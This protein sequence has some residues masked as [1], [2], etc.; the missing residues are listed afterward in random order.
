MKHQIYP[1]RVAQS[2]ERRY[3]VEVQ[4]LARGPAH[5]RTGEHG[6]IVREAD[7]ARVECC[8]PERGEQKAVVDVKALLGVT[9]GRGTMCQPAV[10]RDLTI[11]G[12][13]PP[14]MTY[15]TM[16]AGAAASLGRSIHESDSIRSGPE[17]DLEREALV[18]RFDQFER[19]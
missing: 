2:G 19:I 3:F 16:S 18:A 10:A 7:E 9:V 14:F 1:V 6:A 8:V 15:F 12:F 13:R 4:R 5:L 17:R 11:Y